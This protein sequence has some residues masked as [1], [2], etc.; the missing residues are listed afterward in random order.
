MNPPPLPPVAKK[1]SAVT[2]GWI[3]L[4]L[5]FLTFWIFGL[6]FLFFGVTIVLAIVAMS[7]NQVRAGVALLIASIGSLAMCVFIFML[8]IMGTIGAI[9]L[10]TVHKV[11]KERI[12]T[13]ITPTPP[14]HP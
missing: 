1:S 4:I 2:A 8:V 13:L 14:L 9:G 10:S 5:G 12:R 3:C 6:G 7:T 11:Q